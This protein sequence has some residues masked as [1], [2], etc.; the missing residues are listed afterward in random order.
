MEAK[1]I[2][3]L[4]EMAWQG[5]DAGAA[6][7]EEISDY[8]FNHPEIGDEEYLSSAYLAGEME[9]LGFKVTCPYMGLK[10]AFRCEYGDE[11]GPAIG[12]LAEY[13]ALRGY[14][15]DHNEMAHA[16]GHNWIAASTFA[17]CAALKSMKTEWKGKIVYI[18][19]PAEESYGRKVD[20]AEMGVFDDLAA[21][22]QMHLAHDTVVDTVA[23]AMT[24]F[25][26]NFEGVA[27]HASSHPQK[28]IN[29]LDACTL[30][31]AGI[32]AL[33]QH[34]ESDVRIHA[35]I[36]DGGKSPNIVP[37]HARMAVYVRAGQKDYLEEVIEK[38]INC[39]RGAEL[40]TG[41]R[42]SYTR[43][44]N[45][46]HD[47]KPAPELAARMKANL[48]ALGISGWIP[49]DRYHSGS[50]DIGNV[51]YR[52]PTCYCTIGTGHISGAD[53]HEDAYLKVVNSEGS[54][55]LLHIAAK[56]MAATALDVIV[57]Q[58]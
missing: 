54:Y 32:N 37:E 38:V 53:C 21:V 1:R 19:T 17:A 12:F 45:T 13:D 11:E 51:S 52:C 6:W 27:A 16:C 20:L 22:F 56:A 3:E 30:T 57:E 18:G 36:T 15:S 47:I 25:I 14:G 34:L 58:L 55:R 49:G 24:D 4:K 7:F 9:K 48:K 40:M 28:G 44:E 8:I 5:E 26:F 39:A 23:L 43:A 41:A 29:A 50:T 42:F 2:Q 33:R 46:F 10:T 35:I 31:M